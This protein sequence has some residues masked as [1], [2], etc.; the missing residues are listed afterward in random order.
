MK[1]IP[2]FLLLIGLLSFQ[3]STVAQPSPVAVLKHQIV[4]LISQKSELASERAEILRSFQGPYSIIKDLQEEWIS[5]K[6]Q[7]AEDYRAYYQ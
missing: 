5:I 4:E 6:D 1:N 7:V 2:S 3:A